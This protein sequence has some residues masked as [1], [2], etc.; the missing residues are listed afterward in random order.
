ML[1]SSRLYPLSSSARSLTSGTVSAM[2][3][4]VRGIDYVQIQLVASTTWPSGLVVSAVGCIGDAPDYF[5]A[6]PTAIDKTADGLTPLI[7]TSG[8]DWLKVYTSTTADSITVE[9]RANALRESGT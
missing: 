8:V 4:D 9:V 3:F 7:A 5:G 6:F 1:V 2:I